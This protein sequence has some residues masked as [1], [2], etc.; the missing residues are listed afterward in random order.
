L[1]H[2]PASIWCYCFALIVLSGCSA[3]DAQLVDKLPHASGTDGRGNVAGTGGTGGRT[4]AAGRGGAG[5]GSG[6][7]AGVPTRAGAGGDDALGGSGGADEAGNGGSSGNDQPVAGSVAGD[8]GSGGGGNAGAA[9]VEAGG[10]G[11]AGVAGASGSGGAGGVAGS[12]SDAGPCMPLLEDCC[13]TDPS[14]TDPGVCG[15]GTPD[16]DWDS[17]GIADCAD[18]APYGWQRRLTLDGAQVSAALTNFPVLVRITDA[19]LQGAASANGADI[20]FSAADQTTPLDFELE[21]YNST[22]GA[23]L[24]WVRIP[25]LVAA[26]DSVLYLGYADGKTNRSNVSGVW[27]GHHNVWHLAQDPSA[28]SAAI[29]DATQRAHGT[30]QGSMSGS[31]LVAGVVGQGLSFDGVDDQIAFTNDITGNGPSTLSAWVK[32]STDSGD[33]GSGVISLGN[34]STNQARFLLSSADSQKLKCGFYGNDDLTSTILATGV[35][36][37]LAW[38]W[39]GSK[40]TVFVDGVSVNGPTTHSSVNTSGSAGKIGNGTFTFAY[41]MTG[42]LDEVRVATAARSAAWLAAEFANQRPSST[43]IKSIAAAQ[44]AATH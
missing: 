13:P 40:T 12:S 18:A 26:T 32:Q 35:W 16:S 3:Y 31:A 33:Y 20:Y 44:A 10:G 9:G 2:S 7:S 43:F 14:K 22:T 11:N 15:C 8:G 27:S 38:T 30:A 37:Y 36:K 24:A 17:D 19:H 5:A 6:G 25:S 28:G 34:D 39:D 23:L 42:Q 41:F 4:P 21:S 1:V 29:K